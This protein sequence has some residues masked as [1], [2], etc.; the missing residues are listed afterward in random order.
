MLTRTV[1]VLSRHTSLNLVRYHIG[2]VLAGVSSRIG[3]SVSR[4]LSISRP[5]Q[6]C[7][8]GCSPRNRPQFDARNGSSPFSRSR[9][10]LSGQLRLTDQSDRLDSLPM[11]DQCAADSGQP[12]V[13]LIQIADRTRRPGQATVALLVP[14]AE[15]RPRGHRAVTMLMIQSGR[16]GNRGI[17]L[18]SGSVVPLL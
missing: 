5:R 14:S 18:G 2:R 6:W 17:S 7:A 12:W 15:S 3:F 16:A 13:A 11:P 4:G 10:G 1:P 8:A 9:R